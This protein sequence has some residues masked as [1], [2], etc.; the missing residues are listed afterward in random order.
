MVERIDSF[1]VD[2]QICSSYSSVIDNGDQ[3]KRLA[4]RSITH[5]KAYVTTKEIS[6]CHRT[7]HSTQT[8]GAE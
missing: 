1:F 3:N 2:L 4:A 7:K 8:H 6:R 5:R